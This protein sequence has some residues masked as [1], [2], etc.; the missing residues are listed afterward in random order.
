[1]YFK[2]SLLLVFLFGSIFL[3]SAF[4]STEPILITI[5][6]DMEKV[7]FD[8]KWTFYTEWKP[9]SLTTIS[10]DDKQI[11]LRTAH[12]ENFIYV[13]VDPISDYTLDKGMDKATVCFDAQN[14]KSK[15]SDKND[16]C[17][18]STLGHKQGTVFQG[19]SINGVY[20]NFQKIPNPNNFIAISNESDEND[21]YTNI[22]HPSYE[23][24]IPTDLIKRSNNYGF[25]LSVYDA[26]SNTF[27]SFPKETIRENILK[28][29]SPDQWGDIVSPDKSLPELHLPLLIFTIMI[30]TF[31][32][33]QSNVSILRIRTS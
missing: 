24:K 21:R 18:S 6:P 9:S 12:Y 17:F 31:V 33:I 10:F 26:S 32:I 25:Y 5:S 3:E 28:I 20:G 16:Y 2:L 23:F 4:A 15:L 30:L 11:I 14:N 27:Y 29:P 13:F 7:I 22:P 8:G 19:G 1:M